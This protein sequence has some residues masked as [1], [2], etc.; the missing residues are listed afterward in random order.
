MSQNRTKTRREPITI[1][2]IRLERLVLS[3]TCL[4]RAGGFGFFCLRGG[5]L[6]TLP[7]AEVVLRFL[8][9]PFFFSRGCSIP[10]SSGPGDDGGEEAPIESEADTGEDRSIVMMF[11]TGETSVMQQ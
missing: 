1:R 11:S 8:R 2:L 7:S 6:S 9:A 10:S 3:R 4:R 5:S